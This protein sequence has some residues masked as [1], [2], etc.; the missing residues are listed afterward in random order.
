MP[1]IISA[2]RRTDIP[3]FYSGW[4]AGRLKAGFTF[5]KHPYS[6]KMTRVSL[7][8]QDVSA[9]VFWSKH[10]GPLLSKLEFIE[11]TSKQLLF[12]FTITANQ[13]LELHAPG[14]REAIEDY[15]YLVRRYSAEQIIWRY[16]PLC[17]T[18]KLSFEVHEERFIQ[19]AEMLKGHA[20]ACSI[21]FVYP[22]KKVI[23]NLRK[24]TDHSLIEM[25][26]EKKREYAGRLARRAEACGIRLYA[27]CND[28]LLSEMVHKASCI[29]GR[30]L[31]EIFNAPIDTRVA[32]TRKECACTKSVDIGAYD[33]CAHGCVYC[34]ATT[35]KDRAMTAFLRHDPEW[36]ALGRQ[37]DDG[38]NET[39]S[40]QQPLFR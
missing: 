21:S 12:H 40:E 11:K 18:D 32:S 13:E 20:R 28:H 26:V 9:I 6:G 22:Y 16:D 31:A 17:I 10:Y 4:F 35:D 30:Y 3:A 36:N 19:C 38:E 34:Y 29:D 2:S 15:H 14:Y 25:S 24:Y 39:T 1:H 37:V 8:P 7:K 5:V 23:N 33:T 27:C